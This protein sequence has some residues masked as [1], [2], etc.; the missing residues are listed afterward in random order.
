MASTV[1]Y[2]DG[3]VEEIH[4]AG[5]TWALEELQTLVGGYIEVV[6]TRDGRWMVV[7]EEGLKKRKPEN[8]KATALYRYGDV[9]L[10]VGVAVVVDTKLELDG[11]DDDDREHDG[12]P[13]IH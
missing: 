6:R 12:G 9:H 10:I 4:P 2:T 3:R 8:E 13:D 7:D 11:P 1:Y 5:A